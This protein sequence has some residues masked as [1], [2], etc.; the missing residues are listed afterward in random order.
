[1]SEISPTFVNRDPNPPP[2]GGTTTTA[3]K[4]PNA[5]DLHIEFN[6]GGVTVKDKGSAKEFDY[7]DAQRNSVDLYFPD[8]KPIAPAP[9]LPPATPGKDGDPVQPPP[10]PPPGT[11]ATPTFTHDDP[12]F[13]GIKSWYWTYRVWMHGKQ[14]EQSLEVHTGEPVIQ[15]VK[16]G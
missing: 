16:A 11:T 5:T 4:R 10:S 1:M 9:Y 7:G 3:K 12:K 15:E 2:A 6:K 13:P 14:V 8:D